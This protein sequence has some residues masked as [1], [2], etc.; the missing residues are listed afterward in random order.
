MGWP[1]WTAVMVVCAAAWWLF[2]RRQGNLKFWRL[3][4]RHPDLAL[5]LFKTDKCWSLHETP[6][7]IAPPDLAG[8]F[9]L[10]IPS[11]GRQVKVW[12]RRPDYLDSQARFIDGLKRNPIYG[13]LGK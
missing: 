13:F 10:F 7:D 5:I 11:L 6:I 12:G 9:T 1:E 3:A 2:L 8:P 4:A